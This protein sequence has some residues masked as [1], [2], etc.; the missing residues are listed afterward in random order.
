[1]GGDAAR[2]DLHSNNDGSVLTTTFGSVG[3]AKRSVE[4]RVNQ[5]DLHLVGW[6]GTESGPVL[7]LA[8][9]GTTFSYAVPKPPPPPAPPRRIHL[10][11][12][13]ELGRESELMDWGLPTDYYHRTPLS[14]LR[15]PTVLLPDR[16]AHAILPTKWELTL[17]FGLLHWRAIGS[18]EV[19]IGNDYRLTNIP[20]EDTIEYSSVR[21]SDV[22]SGSIDDAKRLAVDQIAR[23]GGL[24]NDASLAFEAALNEI[25]VPLARQSEP[26][27]IRPMRT[28]YSFIWE[29]QSGLADDQIRAIVMDSEGVPFVSFLSW[30]WHELGDAVPQESPLRQSLSPLDAFTVSSCYGWNPIA[31]DDRLDPL[32]STWTS[33]WGEPGDDVARPV[34][35]FRYSRSGMARLVDVYSGEVLSVA[36]LRP[37]Y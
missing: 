29:H 10:R 13:T 37:E 2:V 24:P 35:V 3:D 18:E 15:A 12:T 16:S 6:R 11:A 17:H 1:M 33:Y 19:T 27:H 5:R 28:G 8:N 36:R 4:S 31:A 32:D 20:A 14:V 9:S 21:R 26:L 34:Y 25:A 7:R 30:R 22:Y 23:F